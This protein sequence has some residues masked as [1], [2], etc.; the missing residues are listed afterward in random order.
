MQG[1][2]VLQSLLGGALD[3]RLD[4]KALK[5]P[6]NQAFLEALLE[7]DVLR[8]TDLSLEDLQAWLLDGGGNALPQ[9][10][11]DL[12]LPV[13]EPDADPAGDGGF[14]LAA[15]MEAGDRMH[16][17]AVGLLAEDG[18]DRLPEQSRQLAAR[19]ALLEQV[20]L[21]QQL[22]GGGRSVEQQDAAVQP[23][24]LDTTGL[25]GL[26]SYA[27][28]AE[29]LETPGRPGLP[30]YTVHTAMDKPGWGQAV[31]ERVMVMARQ[32]VQQARIQLNPRELGPLE[33][34]I[35]VRED[36][37]AITFTAQHAVTREA[38]ESEL[39][40]LRQL[41]QDNGHQ[42][43][44]VDVSRD[45]HQAADGRDGG[46]GGDGWGGGSDDEPE[47]PVADERIM[48]PRGLVDHYA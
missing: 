19:L 14:E 48:E 6:E 45:Q 39:P 1:L 36:K 33:V 44:D 35:S 22:Q 17:A 47:T 9:S 25:T 28:T 26:Q 5:N 24:R 2:N 18:A 7:S 23:Q 46:S 10:V 12:P 42:D 34:N 43:V 37:T 32:G 20:Q 30:S 27:Q 31:G 21:R 41:L 13:M 11:A 3:G 4:A 15:L 40:R 16:G 38:L 29:M 8:A